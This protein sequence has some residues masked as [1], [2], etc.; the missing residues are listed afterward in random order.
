MYASILLYVLLLH[1]E[2]LPFLLFPAFESKKPAD[3]FKS[4]F[5]EMPGDEEEVGNSV[6]E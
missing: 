1:K 5:V 2:V 3:H 6:A 4:R